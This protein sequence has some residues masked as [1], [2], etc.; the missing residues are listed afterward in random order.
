[1]KNMSPMVAIGF[2]MSGII[3]LLAIMCLLIPSAQEWLQGWRRYAMAVVLAAY[4]SFRFMRARAQWLQT[5]N[6]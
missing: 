1:M 6:R 5:K 3:M 2:F 4:A